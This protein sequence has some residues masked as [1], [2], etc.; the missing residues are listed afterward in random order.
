MK[1][2]IISTSVETFEI[3][4]FA[5]ILLN[6]I[7]NNNHHDIDSLSRQRLR[8]LEL[9]QLVSSLKN[10]V[11]VNLL[12]HSVIGLDNNNKVVE[13]YRLQASPILRSRLTSANCS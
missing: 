4:H 10:L 12:A 7:H 8:H 11:N 13:V 3:S 6:E 1:F 2:Y 5:I 9:E